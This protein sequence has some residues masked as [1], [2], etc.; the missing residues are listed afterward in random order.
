[1]GLG[2]RRHRIKVPRPRT[3]EVGKAQTQPPASVSNVGYNLQRS[4]AQARISTREAFG[5]AGTGGLAKLRRLGVTTEPSLA[6]EGPKGYPQALAWASKPR[7]GWRTEKSGK[8]STGSPAQSLQTARHEVA[9]HLMDLP[10]ETEHGIIRHTGVE[11]SSRRLALS[12]SLSAMEPN[13]RMT[14]V[15]KLSRVKTPGQREELSQWKKTDPRGW[16]LREMR[17]SSNPERRRRAGQ[18]SFKLEALAKKYGQ[19]Y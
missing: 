13:R 16:K 14:T 9:H 7:I 8:L 6:P 17:Q 2:D 12:R 18:M 10:P 15:L 19:D 4:T 5:E 11:S 3:S 1:M